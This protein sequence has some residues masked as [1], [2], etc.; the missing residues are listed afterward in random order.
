MKMISPLKYKKYQK[1]VITQPFGANPKN[2][3]HHGIKGH[4]GIDFINGHRK[5]CY[6]IGIVATHKGT[7]VR[8]VKNEPMSTKG[9]G[10][11]IDLIEGDKLYKSVYWHLSEVLVDIGDKVR[12]GQL[13]GRMGNS[14]TVRPKPTDQQPYAGTHL[15]FGLYMYNKVGTHSWRRSNLDYKG[16]VD[17]MPYFTDRTIARRFREQKERPSIGRIRML[18]EPLFWA[19]RIMK[20]RLK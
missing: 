6:G 3:A 19:L 18:L 16:A 1:T 4:N 15:H 13:I 20:G 5:D 7:V 14:G 8:V 17:P 2:Y 9:N 10:T 12:A 11:Y